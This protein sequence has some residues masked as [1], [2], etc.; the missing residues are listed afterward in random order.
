[1]HS[2]GLEEAGCGNAAAPGPRAPAIVGGGHAAIGVDRDAV[3]RVAKPDGLQVGRPGG[4]APGSAVQASPPSALLYQREGVLPVKKRARSTPA[5][6]RNS[7]GT[8]VSPGTWTLFQEAP[9]SVVM[10][11][12]WWSVTQAVVP[13]SAVG[14]WA[15]VLETG[16]GSAGC[17]VRPPSSDRHKETGSGTMTSPLWMLPLGYAVMAP[18][19]RCPS[20]SETMNAGIDS[21]AG[22]GGTRTGRLSQVLAPSVLVNDTSF[23]SAE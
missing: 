20:T 21:L 18:H 3:D 23:A 9:W 7:K 2:R 19:A 15:A 4:W 13:S 14:S 16:G 5:D 12:C 22:I 10:K 11:A 1:M 6:L 17:H 8:P